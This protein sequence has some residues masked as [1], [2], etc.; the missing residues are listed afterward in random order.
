[1]PETRPDL[2]AE[3]P[4]PTST[5]GGSEPGALSAPYGSAPYGSAPYGSA[6]YGSARWRPGT[7]LRDRYWPRPTEP[8]SLPVVLLLALAGCVAATTLDA[9]VG[10]QWPVIAGLITL[11]CTL[12][13]RRRP[14]G[15]GEPGEIGTGEIGHDRSGPSAGS[16]S[17]A[18]RRSGTVL[19][20]LAVGLIGVAAVR[21]SGPLIALCLLAG[22]V[23]GAVAASGGTRWTALI[24]APAAM[25]PA[26]ARGLV[27]TGATPARLRR[28]RRSGPWLRGLLGGGVLCLLIVALLAW[29]DAAFAG[30][31]STLVPDLAPATW[32]A[33]I[34]LAVVVTPVGVALAFLRAARPRWPE[35]ATARPARPAAEWAIPLVLVVAVLTAFLAVQAAVLFDAYPAALVSGPLTPAARAR[36]GFGQLTVVTALVAGLLAWAARAGGHGTRRE[37]RLLLGLGGALLCLL[38]ILVASAIRRLW[39]YE[40]VFGWTV[41]RVDVG[42]FE[43]WLGLVVLLSTLAWT[44]GRAS[45]VPRLVLGS[46]AACLLALASAGPDALVASWNVDRY[47][48]TG[49]IDVGYLR[50]LSD[51]AAPALSRLPAPLS[52][53][54]LSRSDPSPAP[55]YSANL[56]RARAAAVRPASS[57]PVPDGACGPADGAEGAA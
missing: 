4:G 31:V 2:L 48:H 8:A 46:A 30:L 39:L 10:I 36:Q 1:M 38:L 43:I 41:L 50:R 40:Q 5:R 53:C 14:S 12:V 22:L 42:A 28:M 6:P 45:A 51:D 57:A 29:G 47:Q 3:P 18:G 55:W 11:A 19:A 7:T 49:R 25:A 13:G 23:T 52:D 34:V 54:V 26:A 16:R 21:T 37:R 24:L 33:H 35:P 56:S 32:P 27:W 9:P 44:T 15:G 17:V 20:A